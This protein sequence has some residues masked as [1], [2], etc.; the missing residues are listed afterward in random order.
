MT[1]QQFTERLMNFT[2]TQEDLKDDIK[3]L[4]LQGKEAG[5]DV[6]LISKA[7]TR[8]IRTEREKLD[9]KYE[10]IADKITKLG[11]DKNIQSLTDRIIS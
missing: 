11:S 6:P 2:I 9:E 1:E 5:L 7:V 8:H 10:D 4:K 3:E